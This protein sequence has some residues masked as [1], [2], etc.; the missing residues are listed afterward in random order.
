MPQAA[1]PGWYSVSPESQRYWNG[2]GWT[3]F[4]RTTTPIAPT[5]SG[6]LPHRLGTYIALGLVSLFGVCLL[7]AE[8]LNA[9]R[10]ATPSSGEPSSL[11]ALII[12]GLFLIGVSAA[13]LVARR[14]TRRRRT[15]TADEQARFSVH[16]S[17]KP[18]YLFWLG[19]AVVSRPKARLLDLPISRAYRRRPRIVV[20]TAI[21]AL[22]LSTSIAGA[23]FSAA[24]SYADEGTVIKVVDGDTVDVRIE[25]E[26]VRVRLLNV[27]A[28]EDNSVTGIRECFGGE[29][30]AALRGY[31]PVGSSV[32]L[33]YDR[34]RHDQYGR[35]LAG[36]TNASGTF[37]NAALAG[38][39]LAGPAVFGTNSRFY[40]EVQSA[41]AQAADAQVGV[42][43][44]ALPCAL[45]SVVATYES[46]ASTVLQQS[47]PTGSAALSASAAEATLSVA[48]AGSAS[49]AISAVA[50]LPSRLKSPY[51][52]EI[53]GMKSKV[54]NH[55]DEVTAALRSA[56]SSEAA[57]A[58]AVS[59]KA[60]ADK[61]AAD[62]AAADKAAADQAARDAARRPTT[63]G[64]GSTGGTGGGSPGAGNGGGG[65]GGSDGGG[66]SYTGCRNYNGQGMI[67]SK[68]RPFAPIPC[69]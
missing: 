2:S 43:G 45:G 21:L 48:A 10:L 9:T 22:V 58:K 33:V 65:S 6:E 51:L 38:D 11:T 68:G 25:G 56:I 36:V 16:P 29:A 57:A 39:G 37:V 50:W 26:T 63:G 60:A 12:V 13:L 28:P 41:A 17:G 53:A 44:T 46:Q 27:Q 8:A 69:P 24:P 34:E 61:A 54:L 59:E 15:V 67:D 47:V 14:A 31:L 52:K 20:T 62:R 23:G 1:P 5:L 7:A 32:S 19:D 49:T 4:L 35:V 30:T 18:G 64:S 3:N 42:F 66:S 55:H 40:D